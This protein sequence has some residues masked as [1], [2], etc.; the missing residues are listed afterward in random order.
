MHSFLYGLMA[1]LTE[2]PVIKRFDLSSRTD[3][4][5]DDVTNSTYWRIYVPQGVAGSCEGNIVFG[6]TVGGGQ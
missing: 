4:L 1:N 6:A 3:D 2:S 5:V